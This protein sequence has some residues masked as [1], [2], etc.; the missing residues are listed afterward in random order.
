MWRLFFR[1]QSACSSGFYTSTVGAG[2]GPDREGLQFL[3]IIL[4]CVT[5]TVTML[6]IVTVIQQV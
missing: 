6:A 2:A 3:G 1:D 4:S 5:A